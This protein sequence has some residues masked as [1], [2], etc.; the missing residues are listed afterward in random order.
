MEDIHRRTIWS[1]SKGRVIHECVV[2]GVSGQELN[3]K[4]EEA[5]DIRVELTMK[6]AI[7]MYHREGADVSEVY[8]QTRVAQAAAE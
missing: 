3:K 2:D 7:C 6:D 1:L 8:S 4:L 5:D